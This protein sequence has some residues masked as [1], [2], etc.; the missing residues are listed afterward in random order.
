MPKKYWKILLQ[1]CNFVLL[2]ETTQKKTCWN[3][4]YVEV[5]ELVFSFSVFGME[6]K[7]YISYSCFKNIE[8]TGPCFKVHIKFR[9]PWIE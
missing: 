2:A 9:F 3:L 6:G 5:L 8:G 1:I 7:K 4:Q